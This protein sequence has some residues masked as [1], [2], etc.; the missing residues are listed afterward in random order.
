VS[1]IC[2]SRKENK[3]GTFW[4]KP[5]GAGDSLNKCATFGLTRRNLK[6]RIQKSYERGLQREAMVL[7]GKI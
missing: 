6:H 3:G 4:G 2:S 1:W 7:M 5:Q